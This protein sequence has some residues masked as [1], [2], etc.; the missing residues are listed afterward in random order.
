VDADS[1]L[2]TVKIAELEIGQDKV[3]LRGVELTGRTS[4]IERLASEA[5]GRPVAPPQE[6]E[7]GSAPQTDTE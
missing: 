3:V 4:Q 5:L 1:A 7:E 2:V 6:L